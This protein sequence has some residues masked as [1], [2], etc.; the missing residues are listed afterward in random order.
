[1]TLPKQ[2]FDNKKHYDIGRMRHSISV[3]NYSVTDDG[4]GGTNIEEQFIHATKAGKEGVSDY[5]KAQLVAGFSNYE[6]A[7]YFVVRNR[8]NFYPNKTHHINFGGNKYN[9]VEVIE[10]DDPCTFLKILCVVEE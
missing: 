8:P 3:M 9:V 4:F 10:L 1:M 5:K 2:P 6:S 7:I